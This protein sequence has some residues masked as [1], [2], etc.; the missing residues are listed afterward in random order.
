[1]H[2]FLQGLGPIVRF[3][4]F[5][6][7]L[8]QKHPHEDH[9]GLVNVV[10]LV[11]EVRLLVGVVLVRNQKPQDRNHDHLELKGLVEGLDQARVLRAE[12]Q[13]WQLVK[14]AGFDPQYVPVVFAEFDQL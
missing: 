11:N 14:K 3:Q 9:E 2:D 12:N 1:M 8:L 5:R 13:L 10:H 4:D 6:L 7:K